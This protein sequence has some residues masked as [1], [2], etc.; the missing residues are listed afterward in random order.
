[1]DLSNYLLMKQE[2]SLLVVFLILIV[3]DLFA[4]E[5][6]KRYSQPLACVLFLAHTVLGF[7]PAAT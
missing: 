2:I 4:P 1:M 3:Y 5:K 6:S 7:L